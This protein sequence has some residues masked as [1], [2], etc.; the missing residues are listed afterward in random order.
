MLYNY[1]AKMLHE[2]INLNVNIIKKE[3]KIKRL[4]L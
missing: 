4:Y 2:T 1:N 3:H